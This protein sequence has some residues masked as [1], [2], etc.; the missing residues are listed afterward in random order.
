MAE[1]K[2]NQEREKTIFQKILKKLTIVLKATHR[3]KF[4]S[5]CIDLKI[6]PP[7]LQVNPPKNEASQQST[8]W[9]EYVNLANSTSLKNLKIA[10]KDAKSLLSVEENN[11][12]E[13]ANAK[14]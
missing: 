5:D 8:T 7:T 1:N 6:V 11:Y 9:N 13:L 2:T 3:L 4:L 14:K 10:Q 12:S